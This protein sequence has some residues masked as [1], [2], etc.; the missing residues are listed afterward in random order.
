MNVVCRTPHNIGACPHL[1]ALRGTSTMELDGLA[2]DG[3]A[4]VP[5]AGVPDEPSSALEMP[6]ADVSIGSSAAGDQ[7]ESN[8]AQPTAE[9]ADGGQEGQQ[10]EKSGAEA[11]AAEEAAAADAQPGAKESESVLLASSALDPVPQDTGTQAVEQQETE[12]AVETAEATTEATETTASAATEAPVLSEGAGTTAQQQ[13]AVTNAPVDEAAAKTTGE[14]QSSAAPTETNAPVSEEQDSGKDAPALGALSPPAHD[15]SEYDPSAPALEVLGVPHD[16]DEY[17]PANPSPA[18]TPVMGQRSSS[19]QE[20]YDPDHPS[21]TEHPAAMEVDSTPSSSEQSTMTPA[22]RKAEGE[23]SSPS[24]AANGDADAKRPR[25]VEDSKSSPR[26]GDHKHGRHRRGSGDSTSSSSSR[27]THHDDDH[28]GLAAAAWDRLMDFQTSGEFRVTQVSRAA[29][30]SVGA[31]PEFAQ[32]AIIARF[33]RTPMQ[34]IR[35]KNGQL[36]RIFREYQKE[37]PQV[38]ALQPVDAFISDYKSDPGLFR[39]GYAPPQPATGVSNVQ[40]PYQRDQP[41]PGTPGRNS[42]RQARS[43]ATRPEPEQPRKGVDEFGRAAHADKPTGPESRSSN[44]R[45]AA[46]PRLASRSRQGP[47]SPG[48]QAP[49]RATPGGRAEDPRR[50]DQPHPQST[51]GAGRDPRDPRRRG[52]LTNQQPSPRGGQPVGG[53]SELYERLPPPVKAVL[54]SMR[55]EGRLQQSLNDN[56]VTRL[57]HLPERVALQAVENFSNVDLSQVGNLQGFLV[58]IINR[59]NEKAIASEKQ[60]QPQPMA[61]SPRGHA[62]SA[63]PRGASYGAPPQGRSVLGG[64]PQGGRLNGNNGPNGGAYRG[65]PAPMAGGPASALY[66]RPYE[67]PQDPR[68]PRRRQP[69]PQGLPQYGGAVRGPPPVGVGVG[70]VP[71]GMQSFTALPLSVQNHIQSLVANRTLQ[72]LDE[73][74][75]KCYE[76]LSQLSEP[77]ANQ[78]IARFA[79]ANLSN[80]RNKSGFLIG[81]VKRARQEYGFN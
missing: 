67:A 20:E 75:S 81:V 43:S 65:Q 41:E 50:R 70:R 73:L 22:K 63:M 66:E 21:M 4:T 29:F 38:A 27:H 3:D 9:Q 39:F 7:Q 51:N 60:H 10:V 32:I 37:N 59:V 17:D 42:P 23:P 24:D 78:V 33:V 12:A 56:V 64:P 6:S 55:R 40:V 16:E 26:D 34:D 13:E 48:A 45:A 76:V 28:K 69:A 5:V 47:A 52:P 19:E 18:G 71:V 61:P 2:A 54:D 8:E 35:D 15:E 74:G 30:A 31:M 49:Q 79:G 46:D 62:P 53:A 57:L 14:V 25:H 1:R 58:G 36:M 11:P 72:S 68:D 80:V 77:L 44:Q